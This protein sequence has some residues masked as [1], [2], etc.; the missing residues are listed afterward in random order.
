VVIRIR[1]NIN[2]KQKRLGL[3]LNYSGKSLYFFQS[4]KAQMMTDA[5]F[6][7]KSHFASFILIIFL[8]DY[9]NQK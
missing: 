5:P 8:R 9:I 4:H 3:A 2:K 1:E 6:F 7:Q